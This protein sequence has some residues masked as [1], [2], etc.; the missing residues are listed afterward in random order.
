MP[1]LCDLIYIV[2]NDR[3]SCCRE[4]EF[5]HRN[6]IVLFTKTT[7]LDTEIREGFIKKTDVFVP[8]FHIKPFVIKIQMEHRTLY[9]HTF[10]II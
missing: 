1:L 8:F 6:P 3:N 10:F 2:N 4:I 9:T 7:N 5:Q